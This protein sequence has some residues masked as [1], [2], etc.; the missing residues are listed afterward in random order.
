MNSIHTKHLSSVQKQDVQIL[1]SACKEAEM[2]SLSAPLEDDLNYF[3]LY[4]KKQLISMLFLF[5]PEETLCECGAFT[6]PSRRKTGCFS[7]LLSDAAAHV[8]KLEIELGTQIEFCF[9]ADART[10]SA[11]YTLR[12]IGAEYWYSEYGMERA[13]TPSDAVY[14]A[15]LTIREEEAHIYTASKES[16]IIGTCILLPSGKN[17]YFYGFEVKEAY[18][19]Q[20]YGQEFLLGMLALMADSGYSSVSLQV[21]GRNLPALSLYKKTGFRITDTLSYYLFNFPTGIAGVR[22]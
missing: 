18:R 22:A 12:A 19:R 6:L 3:L 9:L 10:P 21:S 5:F 1:V 14:R 4:E 15:N 16:G 8:E 20:G 7:A 11:G 2:L 13:L 17:I